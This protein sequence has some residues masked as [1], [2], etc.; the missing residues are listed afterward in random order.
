MIMKSKQRASMRL[1]IYSVTSL[2]WLDIFIS[3]LDFA[4]D[5]ILLVRSET[6]LEIW[7][8]WIFLSANGERDEEGEQAEDWVNETHPL[9]EDMVTSVCPFQV[10]AH[11]ERK[12]EPESE[13]HEVLD[14]HA[15]PDVEHVLPP[16]ADC[17]IFSTQLSHGSCESTRA[18]KTNEVEPATKTQARNGVRNDG[19]DHDEDPE[20]DDTNPEFLFD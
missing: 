12:E 15:P 5:G 7:G 13:W 9:P 2:D 4:W 1:S 19:E 20:D 6:A 8:E 18:V 3:Q 14:G 10:V 11:R 16:F 17:D